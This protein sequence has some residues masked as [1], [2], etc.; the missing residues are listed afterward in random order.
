ME[1]TPSGG[2]EASSVPLS[3]RQFFPREMEALLHY[4]GFSDLRF[5][6]DFSDDPPGP[7]ADSL[8][9]SATVAERPNRGRPVARGRSR[10]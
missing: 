1:M 5:T 7:A 9:A 6:A 4:N 8:V 10:A 2:A 3:H